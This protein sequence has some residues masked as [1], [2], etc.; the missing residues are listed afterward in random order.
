MVYPKNGQSLPLS[1]A[2]ASN[3]LR[4]TIIL[5]RRSTAECV[6]R[7]M[8]VR[9]NLPRRPAKSPRALHRYEDLGLDLDEQLLLIRGKLDHSPP[10]RGVPES[11]E[12]FSANA[13]IRMPHVGR[14]RCLRQTASDAPELVYAHH[15]PP[16]LSSRAGL[17]S[18]SA[19][20]TWQWRWLHKPFLAFH[21]HDDEQHSI[22]RKTKC[23][24]RDN[25]KPQD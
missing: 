2:A 12:D 5:D 17:I 20:A 15:P 21:F 7:L 10:R 6:H 1:R 13:K 25:E 16:Y 19:R 9:A 22:N 18:L 14:L 4:S 11:R 8:R 23:H 3:G 24:A